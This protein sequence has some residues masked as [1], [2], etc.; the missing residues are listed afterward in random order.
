MAEDDMGRVSTKENKTLYQ[1]K[2]KTTFKKSTLQHHLL[3]H[4]ITECL[5]Y[6]E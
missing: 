1:I 2:K 3:S 5:Q 6:I 4:E